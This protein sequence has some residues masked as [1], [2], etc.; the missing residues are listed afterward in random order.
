MSQSFSQEVKDGLTVDRYGNGGPVNVCIGG[1]AY[2]P[3]DMTEL[4]E[5]LEG[6]TLV[7]NNPVHTGVMQRTADWQ[8]RL[9][10]MYADFCKEEGADF[11]I[12]HSCGSYDAMAIKDEIPSLQGLVMLTPPFAKPSPGQVT[13]YPEFELLDLCLADICNDISDERYLQMLK[14]HSR[15]YGPRMKAIYKNEIPTPAMAER[16]LQSMA[17]SRLPLLTILG[18]LDRWNA[19]G[20]FTDRTPSHITLKSIEHGHYPHISNPDLVASLINHWMQDHAGSR[21][22]TSATQEQ[23]GVEQIAV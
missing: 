1:L 8:T 15:E 17:E 22:G 5:R 11:I 14:D 21:L 4:G 9:R 6:T 10:I 7:L 16:I 18:N 12:G 19:P 13:R 2:A 3:S 20:R 23:R